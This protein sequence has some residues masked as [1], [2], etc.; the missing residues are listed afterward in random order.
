MAASKTK[1][2]EKKKKEVFHIYSIWCKDKCAYVGCTQR[3]S[4]EVRWGEHKKALSEGKHPTKKLQE[5]Y[6][7]DSDF[8]YKLETTLPSKSSFL[9]FVM[10]GL[11]NSYLKPVA[12]SIV[13]KKFRMCTKLGRIENVDLCKKIID[14]VNET[15]KEI[16]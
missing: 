9:L 5:L 13:I 12:N 1:K 15:Y 4:V 7:K 2:Q 3:E 8:T 14:L 10:E 16:D 6:N 11:Y